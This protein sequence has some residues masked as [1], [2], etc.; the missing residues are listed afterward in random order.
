MGVT[1]TAPANYHEDPNEKLKH[2]PKSNYETNVAR[3]GTNDR[4][5]PSSDLSLTF[6]GT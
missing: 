4:Y 1:S 2:N 3:V 5:V 6:T